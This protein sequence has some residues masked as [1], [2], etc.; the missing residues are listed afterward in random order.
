MSNEAPDGEFFTKKHNRLI[1]IAKITKIG[2]IIAF[3][4]YGLS[5]I[6]KIYSDY[7]QVGDILFTHSFT[8]TFLSLIGYLSDLVKA[9]SIGIVLLGISYGLSMIVETDLNCRLK[10]E[11]ASND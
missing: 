9:M 6:M 3:I 2:A 5:F 8:F 4:L 10:K 1:N 11:E 7:L